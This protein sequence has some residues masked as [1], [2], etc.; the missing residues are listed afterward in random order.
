MDI[1]ISLRDI[2]FFTIFCLV[3]F[4]GVLFVVLLFNLI[5]AVRKVNKILDTNNDNI[6]KTFVLLPE[7]LE[8]TNEMVVETKNI[9]GKIDIAIDVVDDAFDIALNSLRQKTSGLMDS[10]KSFAGTFSFII[11]FFLELFKK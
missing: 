10:F 3:S 6:T 7:V 11:S 2:M 9:A 8:N 4:A 5:T 1:T